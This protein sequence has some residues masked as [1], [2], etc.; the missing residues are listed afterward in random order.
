MP[1]HR[2]SV[3]IFIWKIERNLFITTLYGTPPFSPIKLIVQF[4]QCFT[5]LFQILKQNFYLF[6]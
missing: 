3:K 4:F 5:E 6:K 1:V 2:E